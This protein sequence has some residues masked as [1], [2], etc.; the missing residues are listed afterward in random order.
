MVIE[1]VD[2]EPEASIINWSIRAAIFSN[3]DESHHLLGFVPKKAG[4]VTSAIYNFSPNL[5]RIITSSGRKYTLVGSPGTSD[6]AKYVWDRW[7][8]MNSVVNDIDVTES[9]ARQIKNLIM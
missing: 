6:D 2:K 1:S 9:Y 8:W 4:R 7:K 5:Q 3:G